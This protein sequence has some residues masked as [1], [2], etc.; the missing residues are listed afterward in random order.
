MAQFPDSDSLLSAADVAL[1]EWGN[2]RAIAL[3]L[4]AI[5]AILNDVKSDISEINTSAND[6]AYRLRHME[7]VADCL[8]G[9]SVGV[10]CICNNT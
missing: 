5:G 10:Q 6:C 8:S 2:E 1:E 3:A 7:R 9:I 4:V